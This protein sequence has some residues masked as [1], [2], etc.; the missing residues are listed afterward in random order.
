M[1]K[2]SISI[3]V[4]DRIGP[5]LDLLAVRTVSRAEEAMQA[6]AEEVENYAKSNAPWSD[7]SGAARAGL[8]A[9]V[10]QDLGEIVLELSHSVEYGIW[11]ELIQN[12]RFAII[13]PT[14]EALGPRILLEAGGAVTGVEGP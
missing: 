13:M 9:E 3:F 2:P 1:A 14:L 5:T 6:G 7:R 10:Y 4:L 8:H 11:L 12:G